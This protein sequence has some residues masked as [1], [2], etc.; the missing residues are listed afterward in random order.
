[1]LAC[2]TTALVT[3]SM[4]GGG[5]LTLRADDIEAYEDGNCQTVERVSHWY[6]SFDYKSTFTPCTLITMKSGKYQKVLESPE[7][8]RKIMENKNGK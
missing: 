4:W 3:F 6:P 7:E 2:I 5:K 1:M 8:V